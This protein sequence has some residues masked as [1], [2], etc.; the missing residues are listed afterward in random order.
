MEPSIYGQEKM[1][2]EAGFIIRLNNILN[3]PIL[4]FLSTVVNNLID[5]LYIEHGVQ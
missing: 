3:P 5:F 4:S 1:I 2:K